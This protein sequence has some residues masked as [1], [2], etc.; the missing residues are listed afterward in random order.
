M[1]DEDWR[2][3]GTASAQRE[4]QVHRGEQQVHRGNS[5]CTEGTAGAEGEQQGRRPWV[6]SEVKPFKSVWLELQE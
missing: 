6:E 4:Q 3:E 2:A 5:R 1:G